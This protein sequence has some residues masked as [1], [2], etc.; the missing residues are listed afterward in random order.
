MKFSV[1]KIFKLLKFFPPTFFIRRSNLGAPSG[2]FSGRLHCTLSSCAS[3]TF[4]ISSFALPPSPTIHHRA[5]AS[6]ASAR[7]CVSIPSSGYGMC[8][9]SSLQNH[10]SSHCKGTIVFTHEFLVFVYFPVRLETHF[11]GSKPTRTAPT[12]Q[13]SGPESCSVIPPPPSL[14]PDGCAVSEVL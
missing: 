12:T 5:S 6:S 1:F 14:Q 4:I 3:V 8:G 2:C 7:V 9:H 11:L 10:P 13:I